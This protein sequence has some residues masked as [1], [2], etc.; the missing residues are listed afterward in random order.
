M[1]PAFP[2]DLEL[3]SN[4]SIKVVIAYEDNLAGQR[5]VRTCE[6]LAEQL[7][8]E[9]RVDTNLWKFEV[10]A[11]PKLESEA[12]QDAAEADMVIISTSGHNDLPTAVKHWVS[13]FSAQKR[14]GAK[15]LIGLYDGG[16][17]GTGPTPAQSYLQQLSK[18]AN[19]DFFWRT[20]PKTGPHAEIPR[21]DYLPIIVQAGPGDQDPLPPDSAAMRD[22][23]IN[24]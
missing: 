8:R 11:L 19:L 10:L 3:P 24:E 6:R 23:G 22:W 14:G 20:F 4:G 18:R 7:G 17:A 2:G 1:N 21:Q 5:A 13:A 12:A 15:A 16:E 9:F